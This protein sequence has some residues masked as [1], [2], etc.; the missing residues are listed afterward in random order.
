MSASSTKPATLKAALG[1]P[2]GLLLFAENS[3]FLLSTT[4]TAFGPCNGND[5]GT[6]SVQL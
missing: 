5:E 4:E 6:V 2:K 1:T 3:Q